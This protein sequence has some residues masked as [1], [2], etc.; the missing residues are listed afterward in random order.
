MI[1]VQEMEPERCPRCSGKTIAV[2]RNMKGTR[3]CA[4]CH[5]TWN[6]YVRVEDRS[7]Q[8]AREIISQILVAH[9]SSIPIGYINELK[10]IFG[11]PGG[12]YEHA[13]D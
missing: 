3:S 7:W 13:T 5:L 11:L 10:T 4:D 1:T 9:G 2:A 12:N 6:P 8:R